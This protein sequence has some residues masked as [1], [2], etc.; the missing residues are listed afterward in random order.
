[1]V[2]GVK[3]DGK[4]LCCYRCFSQHVFCLFQKL[5]ICKKMSGSCRETKPLQNR[6]LYSINSKVSFYNYVKYL[7]LGMLVKRCEIHIRTN[8]LQK[9]NNILAQLTFCFF[10]NMC[11]WLKR[12]CSFIIVAPFAFHSEVCHSQ[13]CLRIKFRGHCGKPTAQTLQLSWKYSHTEM[14]LF[15]PTKVLKLAKYL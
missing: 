14:C 3:H 7:Y 15:S 4:C 13:I 11:K 6:Y 2:E 8:L 5:S 1:M 10:K 9:K 12:K